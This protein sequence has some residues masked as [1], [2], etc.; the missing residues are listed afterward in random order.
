MAGKDYRGRS[1]T[2]Y[3]DSNEEKAEWRQAA[4]ASGCSI[5]KYILEKMRK[6]LSPDQDHPR[7]DLSRELAEVKAENRDLKREVL[8]QADLIGKYESE[9]YKLRHAAFSELDIEGAREHDLM[10]LLRE[11][12]TINAYDLQKLLRI[13]PGDSEAMRL[14]SNQLEALRRFGLVK[15]TTGGWRWIG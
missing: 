10:A 13:D 12:R 7:P 2:V 4:E 14:V 8:Q 9:L 5:S 1:T 3:A 15:E 11:G 6:A